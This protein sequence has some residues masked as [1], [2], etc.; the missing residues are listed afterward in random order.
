MHNWR[1][2]LVLTACAGLTSA[3][4]AAAQRNPFERTFDVPAD[5]TLDV[6][7]LHGRIEISAGDPGRVVIRGIATVRLGINVPLDAAAIAKAV[8]A[9]PPIERENATIR[10][11]PPATDDQRRAVTISYDVVVPKGTRVISV[12]DSGATSIRDVTGAVSVRTQSSAI[13]LLDLGGSVDV[14]TGSGAVNASGVAGDMTVSTQSSAISLRKLGAGLRLRTQSG[15]VHVSLTGRGNVD[16]ETGSSAIDV[17]GVHGGLDAN[18]SSGSIRIDGVPTSPWRVTGGSGRIELGIDRSTAF[19]L[20]AKSGSSSV[21]L[22]GIAFDGTTSKG[23]ATGN[24][25]GGGPLVQAASRSGAIR[26]RH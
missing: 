10:L 20:D 24:V 4:P 25:G 11:R 21:S 17:S 14:R 22:D 3:V 19:T 18:S 9:N 23:L 6:S 7:T 26:I 2:L 15:A 12:T 13:D 16:V 1:V 5:A 8:A